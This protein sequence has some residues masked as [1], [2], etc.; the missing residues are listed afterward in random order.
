METSFT[1]KLEMSDDLLNWTGI[2][3]DAF[4]V[5]NGELQLEL[6]AFSPRAF[7]RLGFSE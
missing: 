7:F 5:S 3:H 4:E 6:E 1:I 2:E